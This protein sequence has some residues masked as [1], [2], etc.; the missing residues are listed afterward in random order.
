MRDLYIDY[1]CPHLFDDSF[2][3]NLAVQYKTKDLS[4]L[5]VAVIE[6]K[7]RIEVKLNIE[8]ETVQKV[9]HYFYRTDYN[10]DYLLDSNIMYIKDVDFNSKIL[11]KNA[12]E[13]NIE[14]YDNEYELI[15]EVQIIRDLPVHYVSKFL[16]I[17]EKVKRNRFRK[18]S[19]KNNHI[20]F[21]NA[22]QDCEYALANKLWG[23]IDFNLRRRY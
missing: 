20:R 15:E 18:L 16:K 9:R 4:K 22:L 19:S 12:A 11:D 7:C 1:N 21:L 3:A 13:H 23:K 10:G 6:D 14:Q 17:M 5:Q 8:L 2:I